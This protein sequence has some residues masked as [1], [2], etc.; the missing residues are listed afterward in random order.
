MA[1]SIDRTVGIGG[2][3]IGLIGTGIVVLWPQKRWLGWAFI[4]LG[5]L[6]AVV[7]IVWALA[8]RHARK[9]FADRHREALPSPT[10]Q[11]TQNALINPQF[12]P[13]IAPVFAPNFNQAQAQEQRPR[14][15][16]PSR[17][18]NTKIAIQCLGAEFLDVELTPWY[19]IAPRPDGHGEPAKAAI[20]EFRRNA[21][22]P[23]VD[24]INLTAQIELHPTSE[25]NS[26]LIRQ[27]RW[28]AR[29]EARLALHAS[30]RIQTVRRLA[31]A[32]VKGNSA[33]TYEG[34]YQKEDIFAVFREE[35]Q[36]LYE[37][38][39]EVEV[40]LFGTKQNLGVTVDERF[41][42]ELSFSKMSFRPKD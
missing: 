10:A 14:I 42:F 11:L 8:V 6:I 19:E 26:T 7:A 20:I 33:V 27:A 35:F 13:V 30:F 21:D 5:V 32:L 3:T 9:E 39:Y 28:L 31:V 17:Y 23:A 25:R 4:G 22:E 41:Y 2:V 29:D 24:Y 38:E 15:N 40:H 36:P 1:L 16:D 37:D 12:N 34:Y 18:K